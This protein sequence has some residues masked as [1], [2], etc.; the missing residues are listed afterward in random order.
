MTYHTGDD[1]EKFARQQNYDNDNSKDKKSE[2]LN[3]ITNNQE[4]E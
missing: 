1:L 3:T 2:Q 4:F